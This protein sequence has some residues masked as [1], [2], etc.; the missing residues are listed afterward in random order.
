MKYTL[1]EQRK[2]FAIDRRPLR[3]LADVRARH[4]RLLASAR[5]NHNAYSRIVACIRQRVAQLFHS[6]AIQSIQ[7]LRPVERDERNPIALLEQQI[8]KRHSASASPITRAS[9][10]SVSPD[11]HNHKIRVR[12]CAHSTP[13]APSASA[14][15][16]KQTASRETLQT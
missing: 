6:L 15:A 16:A 2:I 8:L 11:P 5:Q 9:S 13:P 3:Q 12:L 10:P 4:K 7:H 1:S 14:T